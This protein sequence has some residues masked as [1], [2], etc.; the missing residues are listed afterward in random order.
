MTI[1][2]DVFGFYL[3]WYSFFSE[4]FQITGSRAWNF[5]RDFLKNMLTNSKN[6]I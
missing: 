4:I 2:E 1:K 5:I 3:K 6:M